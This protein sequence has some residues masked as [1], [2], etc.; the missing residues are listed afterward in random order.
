MIRLPRPA[1]KDR[2]SNP[3]SGMFPCFLRL[4]GKLNSI[5]PQTRLSDVWDELPQAD[6][7]QY[8]LPPCALLQAS[9]IS[10][11]LI[12]HLCTIPLPQPVCFHSQP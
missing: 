3:Q 6:E 9:P 2:R 11:P 7:L 1:P 12:S 5:D 8:A 4:V 10:P